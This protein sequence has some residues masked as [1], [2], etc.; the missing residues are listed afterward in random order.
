[1]HY[2]ILYITLRRLI[3]DRD[4]AGLRSQLLQH[5]APL[6]ARALAPGSERV[7]AHASAQPTS[8]GH[9]EDHSAAAVRMDDAV[10][11]GVAR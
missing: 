8:T 2:K 9:S 10:P 1:M 3:L 4:L 6:F 7:I 11:I 5:G